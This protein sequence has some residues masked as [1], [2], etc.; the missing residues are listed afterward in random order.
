M[1]GMNLYLLQTMAEIARGDVHEAC[2]RFGITLEVAHKLAQ[3]APPVLLQIAQ[4]PRC[5]WTVE[6]DVLKGALRGIERAHESPQV[7]ESI[8]MLTRM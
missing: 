2:V 4:S 6:N 7:H 8:V 5:V 3:S 1:V